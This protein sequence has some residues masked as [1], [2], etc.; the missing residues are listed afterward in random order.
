VYSKG[1]YI[2]H[3]G[4]A[5]AAQDAA[6]S[7]QDQVEGMPVAAQ[8]ALLQTLTAALSEPVAGDRTLKGGKH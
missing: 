1:E 4:S 5:A 3:T 7:I 8:A 2:Q 6:S